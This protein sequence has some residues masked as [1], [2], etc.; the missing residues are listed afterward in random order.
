[1]T[2]GL[3]GCPVATDLENIERFE[4]LAGGTTGSGGTGTGG[5][6]SG[7]GGSGTD[8]CARPLPPDSLCDFRKAFT[9]CAKSGCHN[10]TQGAGNLE[11]TLDDLLIAR[12]LNK[13]VNHKIVC[14]TDPCDPAAATCDKCDRCAGTSPVLLSTT[15]TAA[16]PQGFLFEK[17]AQF[18]PGTTTITMNIGCGDAM[19]TYNTTGTANYTQ[20][21]KDCLYTFFNEIAK[22]PGTWPCAIPGGGG[23]AGGAATAGTGGT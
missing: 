17:M 11:L 23:G 13:P 22:T 4:A 16:A 3:S 12:V 20:E 15:S 7:S 10:K 9:F 8:N 6:M 5:G 21:N 1:M 19:P 14:G 18:V 2:I